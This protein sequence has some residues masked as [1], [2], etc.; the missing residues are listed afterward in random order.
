MPLDAIRGGAAAV[1]LHSGARVLEIGAGCG[2]LTVG[3]LEAGFEVV[4]LEPGASLRA[5]AEARAP[6]ATYVA[7]IFEDFSPDDRFDAVYSA[8]AFHWVDPE[9]GYAKVADLADAFVLIW[10]TP[11][12]ADAELR[13]RVQDGVMIPHGSKFPTEEADVR[14]LV[15]D[16]IEAMCGRLRDAGRFDEPWTDVYEQTLSYTPER[17]RDLIGSMG[18]VASLP[19]AD[20]M[21]AELMPVLGSEPFDVVDLVWVIA[22]RTVRD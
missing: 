13:R 22:A 6:A 4:A 15:T 1:G 10:N 2:Q 16:E 9:V 19:D 12:V 8:N 11:F 5:R 3:L 14:Q 18:H 7:L 17:Y 20:V 21:L